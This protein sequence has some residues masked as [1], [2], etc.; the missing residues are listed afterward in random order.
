M[1]RSSDGK[2]NNGFLSFM[3]KEK[4][5]IDRLKHGLPKASTS[6]KELED[7][8][9]KID[10]PSAN[11]E[12]YEFDDFNPNSFLSFD[13][14]DYLDHYH[15]FCEDNPDNLGYSEWLHKKFAPP[16]KPVTLFKEYPQ[17]N[18]MAPDAD[19][20]EK[21][22]YFRKKNRIEN[23]ASNLYFEFFKLIK[24]N[25]PES[26]E[27]GAIDIA[28]VMESISLFVT[29]II[30]DMAESGVQ[31]ADDALELFYGY[32]GSNYQYLKEI[33]RPDEEIKKHASFK[34]LKLWKY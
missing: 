31:D 23:V 19:I 9:I 18:I 17:G 28:I 7:L 22:E 34:S 10:A 11:T 26:Y 32:L 29:F 16:K 3:Q 13:D 6:K 27:S 15:E 12:D 20:H 14:P 4:K 2:N 25:H 30:R 33:S 24:K 5:L 1:K 8:V 21:D